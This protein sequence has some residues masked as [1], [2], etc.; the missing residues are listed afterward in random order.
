MITE[1]LPVR[2]GGLPVALAGSWAVAVRQMRN[3]YRQPAWIVIGLSQPVVWLLLYGALLRKI[4]E[5]PGFGSDSY[6]TFLT[7]GIVVMNAF[8]ASGW[9]GMDVI[10]DVSRGVFDRFLI[11]PIPRSALIVGRLIHSALSTVIQSAILIIL[12]LALGARFPG[13]VPGLLALTACAVLLGI[14]VGGLSSALALVLRKGQSVIAAG[15]FLLLPLTFL[16]SIFIKQ[17]LA[18]GWIQALAHV[19]PVNWTVE[20]GRAALAAPSDWVLIGERAAGLLAFALVCCALAV[21]ALRL[22][23]RAT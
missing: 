20:A 13:G 18:P 2:A 10:D 22:Y 15:N 5:I 12:G 11:T 23:Q 21:R 19:N 17:D 9:S 1:R 6:L 7:P 16:S 8:F 3:L 4:V 14:G